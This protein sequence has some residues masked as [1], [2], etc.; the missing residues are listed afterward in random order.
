MLT[1]PGICSNTFREMRLFGH[2]LYVTVPRVRS[3]ASEINLL[4]S[5]PKESFFEIIINLDGASLGQDH[6]NT[7]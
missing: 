1:N 4:F 5:S 3:K 2:K 7:I 6:L